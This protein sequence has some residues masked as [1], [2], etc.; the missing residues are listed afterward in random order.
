ML[1]ER[2][3]VSVTINGRRFSGKVVFYENKRPLTLVTRGTSKKLHYNAICEM[4]KSEVLCDCIEKGRLI[5]GDSDGLCSEIEQMFENLDHSM[6]RSCLK[7]L[8]II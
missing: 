5:L 6:Q 1:Q 7:G 2:G 4:M 8:Q 3:I